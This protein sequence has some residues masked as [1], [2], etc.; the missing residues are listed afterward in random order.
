VGAGAERRGGECEVPLE[1]FQSRAFQRWY[2]A[3]RAAGNV[4][5]GAHVEW[6]LRVVDRRYLFYWALHVRMWIA[7]EARHKRNEIVLAR[8][9]TAQVVLYHRDSSGEPVFALIRE[10]RSAAA[11]RDGVVHEHCGGSSFEAEAAGSDDQRAVA[12]AELAEEVGLRVDAARLRPLGAR[13]LAPTMSSHR[14]HAFAV[15]LD[16]AELARLRAQ[17]AAGEVHG[18]D[19]GER[20]TLELWTLDELMADDRV[21]WGTLGMAVAAL[22]GP[23]VHGPGVHGPGGND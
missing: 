19:A 18:A 13:Q 4:L 20:T 7:A 5:E 1:I 8:P 23:G 9:D 12:I 17:A 16:A 6:V 3:Q 21:D 10:F 15:E 2:A 11:T 14:A 22:R